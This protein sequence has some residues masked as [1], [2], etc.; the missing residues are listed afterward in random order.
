MTEAKWF[1]FYK[2][3]GTFVYF[4]MYSYQVKNEKAKR[5]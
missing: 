1:K 4:Y 3:C 5:I 2:K